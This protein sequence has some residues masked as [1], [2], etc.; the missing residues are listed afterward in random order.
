MSHSAFILFSN[1]PQSQYVSVI[2]SNCESFSP[3][4]FFCRM[5]SNDLLDKHRSWRIT[6]LLLVLNL[7]LKKKKPIPAV[8][9]RF[10]FQHGSIT[11]KL[12]LK[13]KSLQAYCT[14]IR[15]QLYIKYYLIQALNF[16]TMAIVWHDTYSGFTCWLFLTLSYH[17]WHVRSVAL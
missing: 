15:R 8:C 7:T 10:M 3:F 11:A 14:C 17:C 4:F 1:P 12:S 9:C 2:K 16:L 6:E 5:Q 13:K